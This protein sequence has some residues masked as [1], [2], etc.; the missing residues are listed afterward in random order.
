M[1][2]Q[3]AQALKKKGIERNANCASAEKT[4]IE[5]NANCVRAGKKRHSAQRNLRNL[6]NLRNLRTILRNA[7]LCISTRLPIY[8]FGVILHILLNM[9]F[10]MCHFAY[11]AKYAIWRVSFCIITDA[12]W[13]QKSL[14]TRIYNTLYLTLHKSIQTEKCL[15]K[16]LSNQMLRVIL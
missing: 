15:T 5:R 9:Q 16:C 2:T 14:E 1:Q 13:H 10:G 4:G 11:L 12:I 8:R 3:I 7:H 6:H